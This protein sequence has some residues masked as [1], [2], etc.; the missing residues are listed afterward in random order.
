MKNSATNSTDVQ[1]NHTLLFVFSP[2]P[3][4]RTYQIQMEQI[5]DRRAALLGHDVV[6]TEVF[7]DWQDHV[8]SRSLPPEGCRGLRQQYHVQDGRFRVVLVG[9]DERIKM[10]ADS[11]VSFEEVIM[12]VENAPECVSIL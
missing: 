8:G 6:V 9:K 12:R 7:E 4:H 3:Q 5:E 10:V 1:D 11:C 2:T